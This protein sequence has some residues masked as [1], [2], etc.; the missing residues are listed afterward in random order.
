[1]A[2][3]RSK[4]KRI[5]SRVLKKEGE[6]KNENIRYHLSRYRASIRSADCSTRSRRS[7]RRFASLF[8]FYAVDA[9]LNGFRQFVYRL[10]YPRISIICLPFVDG[11]R[12]PIEPARARLVARAPR[13]P[14]RRTDE[15]GK[16]VGNG[17][18]T[19]NNWI[20]LDRT[21]RD[22]RNETGNHVIARGGVRK[23]ARRNKQLSLV[24]IVRSWLATK[25]LPL[26]IV[27]YRDYTARRL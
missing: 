10:I 27:R 16:V 17:R 24:V 23:C 3:I 21:Q 1:M 18:G 7:Y 22:L 8:R 13:R 25:S 19:I 15:P 6:K 4:R 12:L 2:R 5:R 14:P 26:N 9:Q 11:I 20:N